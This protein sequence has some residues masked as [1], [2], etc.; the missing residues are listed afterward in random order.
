M[1]VQTHLGTLPAG[2]ADTQALTAFA[3]DEK[4]RA[5]TE[6]LSTLSSMAMQT[7]GPVSVATLTA[8]CILIR[9]VLD[10]DECYVIRSG[11]PDFTRVDDAGEAEAYELKQKGYYLV[12]QLLVANSGLAGGVFDAANGRVANLRSLRAGLPS[13]HLA[14]LLPSDESNAEMLIVR[15]P[16]PRGLTTAQVEF[17]VVARPV[18][19]H[20]LTALSAQQR[21]E[22]HQ[23]QLRSIST[24]ARVLTQGLELEAALPAIAT[25]VAQASGSTWVTVVLVDE[26]L[27]HVTASVFNTTRYSDTAIA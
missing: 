25:A 16:W 18:I 14:T 22:R 4:P 24:I 1:S 17:L 21:R 8:A 6:S 23:A 26:T 12:W 15:G 19:A 5:D 20:L 27:E 11:D 10:A 13:T 7:T 3:Y 2:D 9:D